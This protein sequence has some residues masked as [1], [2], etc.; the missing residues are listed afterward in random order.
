LNYWEKHLENSIAEVLFDE[1]T[2]AQKV[3]EIAKQI[4]SDYQ[5]ENVEELIIVGIL[6]GSVVFLSDLIRQI[7]LPVTLDFMAASSYAKGT[8]SSGVVRINK[9]MS[10]SIEGKHVL[11]VEDIIDSGQTLKC[12]TEM[13][14]VR[15]PS[16]LKLCTL[17][18]KPSRRV[19]ELTPD[20]CGF[21]IPDKFVVGYGL[22]FD[23]HYRQLPYIGVLK[24]EIY[25]K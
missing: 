21:E 24:P 25:K 8:S 5:K 12:L 1:Q 3:S 17:L 20:Y 4:T 7:Q 18:D 11:I 15:Q 19:V 16:S 23:E 6:R 2:L 22:D 10:N 13:L 14:Q 9:D